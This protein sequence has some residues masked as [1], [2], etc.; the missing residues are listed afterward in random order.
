MKRIQRNAVILLVV[1][2]AGGAVFRGWSMAASIAIGGLLSVVNF[3]WMV[4]GVDRVI[5][6]DFSKGVR[7]ALL[8]YVVRLLLIFGV[9]FAIIHTS[10]LSVMGALL[11]V[12]VYV[13]AGMLEGVL[14]MF[15]VQ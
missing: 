7:S 13:L 2:V 8:K 3:H 1:F 9:F 5:Y 14:L 6:R 15:K 12:S 4:A 11:G 10:F